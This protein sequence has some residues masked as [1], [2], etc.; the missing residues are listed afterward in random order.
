MLVYIGSTRVTIAA[1]LLSLL[2]FTI[3]IIDFTFC[4]R[5][6]GFFYAFM[7]CNNGEKD[8]RMQRTGNE[9]VMV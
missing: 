8:D 7:G 2:L 6:K 9:L 1:F 4:R 5:K 3:L